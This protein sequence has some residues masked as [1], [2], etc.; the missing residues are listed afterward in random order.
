[1]CPYRKQTAQQLDARIAEAEERAPNVWPP[2]ERNRSQVGRSRADSYLKGRTRFEAEEDLVSQTPKPAVYSERSAWPRLAIALGRLPIDFFEVLESGKRDVRFH[3][4][5]PLSPSSPPL[6]E[7][8]PSGPGDRRV[9]VVMLRGV[10][11]LDDRVFLAVV[12]H[13]LCH[14]VLDH[15]AAIAWPRDS[16]ELRKATAAMENEALRLADEIGFRDE[17]WVLRDI[18]ADLADESGDFGHVLP[19]G[20]IRM[21]RSPPGLM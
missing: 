4:Q 20:S 3:V 8:R 1:M 5:P 16:Y 7:V 21:P 17:T 2:P 11:E 18:I 19:D 15:P 14:V 6:A 13:E 9:Y 10:L 12:V